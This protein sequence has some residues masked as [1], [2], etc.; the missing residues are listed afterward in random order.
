MFPSRALVE[1]WHRTLRHFRF[2]RGP[3]GHGGDLDVLYASLPYSGLDGLIA[4][5]EA[6][7]RPLRKLPPH[8]TSVAPAP[9]G[10]ADGI[11][12]RP[13]PLAIHP[14]YERPGVTRV[15]GRPCLIT[16]ERGAVDIHMCGAGTP[17]NL[18]EVTQQDYLNALA[19]EAEFER[20][21]IVA[22]H[23]KG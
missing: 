9:D 14:G 11:L 12:R 18:W 22:R 4:L 10:G 3:G 19:L 13:E 5:F 20:R 2:V 6:L 8:D 17:P 23:P 7:E 1:Q 15:F 21:G 16:V